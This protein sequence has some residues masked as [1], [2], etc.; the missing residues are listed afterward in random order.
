MTVSMLCP[1]CSAPTE[2]RT[3]PS[4]VGGALELDIC[5]ACRAFWFDKYED[6]QLA[7]AAILT[8]F[9]LI[10]DAPPRQTHLT[11]NL[12]CP[13]CQ[14][15]LLDTHDIQRTTHFRYWRCDRGHGRFMTF[16]DFLREKDFIRPL[17]P[18]QL[19]DLKAQVK[20][21]NC[22]N[23]GAPVDLAQGSTC[24][25]CGSPLSMLD[26]QQASR[27]VQALQAAAAPKPIDPALPLELL[28]IRQ[29][30]APDRGAGLVEVALN[31][32]GEWIGRSVI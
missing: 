17:T 9:R 5:M 18:Q 30:Q 3:L 14:S 26:M 16:F 8:L 21:V 22:S 23:C 4:Q 19:A 24:S 7:P 29:A 6:L 12:H 15:R 31:M 32:L 20:T 28:R 27:A 25:H 2:T 1:G 13:R 11:D 10:G